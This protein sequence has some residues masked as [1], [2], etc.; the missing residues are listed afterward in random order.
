MELSVKPRKSKEKL[1]DS[2]IPAVAYNKENNVTFAIDRKV[3]DRAF[4]QQGTTSLFDITVEGSE[5]FPALVKAVQMDKRKRKPI[6][7]DFY[8]VTYGQAI[9]VNV[10]V[11]TVGKSLGEQEGGLLE[12]IHHTLHVLAP[13]PRRIPE[14]LEVDIS[15]LKIGDAIT[16]AD[17]KLPKD[18]EMLSDAVTPVLQIVAPRVSDDSNDEEATEEAAATEA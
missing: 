15:E 8:M 11:V 5:P 7:V 9:E 17:V 12:I 3:F 6:H 18:C 4:R 1:D 10:P 14:H 13:G 16:A 2:L